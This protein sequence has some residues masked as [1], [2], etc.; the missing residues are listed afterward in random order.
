MQG[1]RIIYIADDGS[2]HGEPKEETIVY[3]AWAY[4]SNMGIVPMPMVDRTM[5]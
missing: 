5:F 2:R 3:V 4:L 1:S